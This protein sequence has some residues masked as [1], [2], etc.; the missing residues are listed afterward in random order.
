MEVLRRKGIRI[1]EDMGLISVV[2]SREAALHFSIP[3]S[4]VVIPFREMA[5]ESLRV[6]LSLLDDGSRTPERKFVSP[7][8][9][10]GTSCGCKGNKS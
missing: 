10:Q 4:T 3:V 1:P 8:F 2:A 7:Y 6:L 5:E 9:V